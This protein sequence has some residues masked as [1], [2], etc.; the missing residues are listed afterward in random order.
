MTGPAPQR[1]FDL[2]S[3]YRRYMDGRAREDGVAAF[4]AARGIDV[5]LGTAG[6][7]AGSWTVHGL[8]AR[9][10]AIYLELLA[11]HGVRV[12]SGTVEPA[13]TAA[14]RRGP[15]RPGDASR[16]AQALLASADLVGVF[17]VVVDGERAAELSLAGKPD[18]AM[19]LRAAR[20]LRVEPAGA[21]WSRT[22]PPESRRPSAPG[23]ASSWESRMNQHP[24]PKELPINSH[25]I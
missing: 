13:A 4:L 15:G 22:R 11:E 6:D 1:P 20:Q 19:S 5:P 14:R 25:C 16:N 18:P 10:N 12:F 3:D 24:V 9:K 17:D 8:G 23:S 2:D 7:P 21:G